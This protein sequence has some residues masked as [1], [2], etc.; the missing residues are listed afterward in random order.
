MHQI[1]F[2]LLLTDS[3]QNNRAMH[4][5]TQMF[6]Y[7]RQ[8][9]GAHC[10]LVEALKKGQELWGKQE[11]LGWCEGYSI[12]E[13]KGLRGQWVRRREDWTNRL[14]LEDLPPHVM[15]VMKHMKQL[16]TPRRGF[17]TDS[18]VLG[19]AAV[20]QRE[21]EELPP[22]PPQSHWQNKICLS[23][24]ALWLNDPKAAADKLQN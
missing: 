17:T 5:F 7:K 11:F 8:P 14:R 21:T 10:S 19:N 6:S 1:F 12:N 22:I 23:I 4:W 16:R 24:E 20:Q 2:I 9:V 3:T 15:T 13:P 18:V